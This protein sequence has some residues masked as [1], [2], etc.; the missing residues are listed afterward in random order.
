M[1]RRCYRW[2]STRKEFVL[3]VEYMGMATQF[4]YF[5]LGMIATGGVASQVLKLRNK[6]DK[7]SKNEIRNP[8]ELKSV[9]GDDGLR[10]SENVRLKE[11][12]DFEGVCLVA[13]TGAGKTTSLFLNNLLDN[14]IRGSYIVTDPKGEIYELTSNYQKNVCGR[15]VYKIDFTDITHSERYNLLSGCK[16]TEDVVQLASSLLLNGALSIELESG[17]KAGGVEWIQMAEPLLSAVLLYVRDLEKPFNTIEFAIQL[18]LSLNNKQM[19]NLIERSK[20]IDALS[21]YDT[22]LMVGGADRTEGSIKITLAS[23]MRLFTSRD[24]NNIGIDTTF[25]IDKFR[26]EESI[27]YVIYPERKCNYLAP[28]IAPLFSQFM[29][30]LLDN[31]NSNSLPVHFMFDEFGNVGM[32][33]NMKVNVATVRSRKINM[34]LCLQSIT[35]LQQIYGLDNSKTILNNLKTKIVLAGVSDVDTL[36]YISTLCGV[37]EITTKNVSYSGEKQSQS[38]SKSKKNIFEDG[39]LR[40]IEDGTGILIIGN[41]MPVIDHIVPYYKTSLNGNVGV[42]VDYPKYKSINYNFR[43]E[44]DMIKAMDKEVEKDNDYARRTIRQIFEEES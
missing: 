27:L 26:E 42:K 31:F 12:Y 38:Y 41:K 17:K 37:E 8:K 29:D 44:I 40:T 7:L 10:L 43:S 13:P 16:T 23:N 3:M 6:P 35:Q 21:Q 18:I 5:S 15:K 4:L 9:M 20:N 2:T 34:T 30:K 33:S 25:S 39:E 1:G 11:K 32:L 36:R 28:F 14:S 24:V 19:Y 22:F